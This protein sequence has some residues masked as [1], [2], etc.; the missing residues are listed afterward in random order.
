MWSNVPLNG[1]DRDLAAYELAAYI[2]Q[3]LGFSEGAVT[4]LHQAAF[5]SG[6]ACDEALQV[7]EYALLYDGVSIEQPAAMRLGTRDITVEDM[8]LRGN[9]LYITG[10]GFN[11]YSRVRLDGF[12]RETAFL[13]AHTLAVE[14][15]Y[16][17]IGEVQVVQVAE[18]GTELYTAVAQ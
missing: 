4:R 15:V 18:D 12:L 1:G 11:E 10:S 7:L 3:L 13:D 17:A 9:T 8:L 2:Q 14:N 6:E 5:S 16:F